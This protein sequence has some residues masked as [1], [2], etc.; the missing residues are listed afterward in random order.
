MIGTSQSDITL[1]RQRMLQKVC[2]QIGKA[3]DFDQYI[4]K[5][6]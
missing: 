5:I 4:Q 1:S 3:K 2:G 6:F